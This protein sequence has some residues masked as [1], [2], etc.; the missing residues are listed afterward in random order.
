MISLGSGFWVGSLEES[1]SMV[2]ALTYRVKFISRSV[3]IS[4][5]GRCKSGCFGNNSLTAARPR[6][7]SMLVYK[8]SISMVKRK[9][10]SGKERDFILVMKS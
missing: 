1:A 6:V 9:E 8:L 10:C 4:P 7:E 2:S 5:S 3:K